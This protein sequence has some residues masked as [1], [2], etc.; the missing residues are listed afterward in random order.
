MQDALASVGGLIREA[1]CSTVGIALSGNAPEYLLW[2]VMGA[3]RPDLRMAWI[4]AGTP[5]ARYEDPSFAPC[6]VVCD[7]SCPS[8]WTTIRGLPLAYERSGYRLFQQAAPAP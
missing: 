5:S 7:E 1:G 8:D 6:A 2:V 3:P 4:V